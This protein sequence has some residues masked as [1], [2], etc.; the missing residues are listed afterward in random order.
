MYNRLS[1]Y[2]CF[3]LDTHNQNLKEGVRYHDI[4]A[5][6]LLLNKRQIPM[7]RLFMF[8]VELEFYSRELA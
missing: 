2:A 5:L 4:E 3:I 6:L 8:T 7:Y 1:T